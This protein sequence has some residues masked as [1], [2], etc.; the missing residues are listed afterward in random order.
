MYVTCFLSDG[1]GNR[2]FQIAAMLGYA[3]RYGHTPVFV[4]EW[5]KHNADQPGGNSICDY[6]PNIPIMSSAGITWTELKGEFTDAMTYRAL[7]RVLGSVKLHG[8]F[9]SPLYFPTGGVTLSGL[10]PR[11]MGARSLFL[12]IRRGDYLHPLNWHHY[13]EL[14]KYYER[15][16]S[17][18]PASAHIV[19]C[20]DDLAWCK[21]VLPV[22][23]PF[24]SADKWIWFA[25]NEYETLSAMAGCTLGGICANSTFSWWGAYIG[26]GEEKIITMPSLWIQRRPGFPLATDIYP[27]W[28]EQ[29]SV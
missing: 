5:I 10:V 18:F 26:R 21:S 12:H 23:Y 14:D 13:V 7:P 4:K 3:E 20:S 28:A 6:F 9:Q 16:L 11:T 8:A 29:V 15:A 27:V 1:L 25:G 24:I 2:L 17:L 19:V 22:R